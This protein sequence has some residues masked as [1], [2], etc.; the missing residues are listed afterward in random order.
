M[1]G[2][3]GD[4]SSV[5]WHEL[6]LSRFWISPFFMSRTLSRQEA[7]RFS[8]SLNQFAFL[9]CYKNSFVLKTMQIYNIFVILTTINKKSHPKGWLSILY[10]TLLYHTALYPTTLDFTALHYTS[11]HFSVVH[12]TSFNDF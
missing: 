2:A 6:R 11:H 4:L 5:S 10:Y 1:S 3:C 7:S 12:C 9:H 8:Q